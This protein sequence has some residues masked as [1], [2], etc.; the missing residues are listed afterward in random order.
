M[1]KGSLKHKMLAVGIILL[2]I[3]TSLTPIVI[4]YNNETRD[5]EQISKNIV[6]NNVN[7]HNYPEEYST[8]KFNFI[9]HKNDVNSGDFSFQKKAV[10]QYIN[11]GFTGDSSEIVEEPI[12]SPWPMYCN[13][14]KHTGR[15]PYNTVNV[16]GVEKW[17]IKMTGVGLGSPI[18][19]SEGVIYAA[20]KYLYAFYP[21]GTIKWICDDWDGVIS[22]TT[23][24]IDKNG[25]IYIGTIWAMPNYLYAINSTN[26]TIEWMYYLGDSSYSSPSVGEDGTI[27]ISEGKTFHAVNSDGT[28]K[29]IFS[30]GDFFWGSSPAIDDSGIVYCGAHDNKLYAWYPNNGSV[31]WT[32]NAGTWIHG[33]PTIGENGII[34]LAADNGLYALYSNNGTMKWHNNIGP[35]W[36]S[37]ALDVNGNIYA[38]TWAEKFYAIYPNG[39]V[40]WRYD[41]PGRIWFGS[42]AAISADGTIYFGTTWMD[43]GEGAFIALNPDGTEKWRDSYRWYESSPAIGVDGTIYVASTNMESDAYLHAFGELDPNAPEAPSIT[44]EIEGEAGVEYEYIFSSIDPNDDDIFYN[45]DWGDEEFIDWFGPYS[46]GEEVVVSHAWSTEGSYTVRARAKDTNNLWGPWGELEVTMPVSQQAYSFP[47]LQRLFEIF[48]NMFPI[49]RQIF[50]S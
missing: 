5:M 39:E 22:Y 25:I 24:A 41:A 38:G 11:T 50:G 1:G 19:D 34:F 26:G 14:V 40:K 15:S 3:V 6:F 49:L 28:R 43:G 2:F 27:Y 33:S 30:A 44:G 48:P 16:T 32:F 21:N 18:I 8:E 47:L 31:K 36:A 46:S 45:V 4:G 29:W 17:R 35:I 20:A 10:S 42:S 37:P 23:P 7:K 9:K 12:D 13:N